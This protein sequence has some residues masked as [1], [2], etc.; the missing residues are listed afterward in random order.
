M[1][2]SLAPLIARLQTFSYISCHPHVNSMWLAPTDG[3]AEVYK[4]AEQYVKLAEVEREVTALLTEQQES[5]SLLIRG[6]REALA[7]IVA[8][9][10]EAEAE[11][12]RLTAQ[13]EQRNE[14]LKIMANGGPLS[15]QTTGPMRTYQYQAVA[16]AALVDQEPR[17]QL[18]EHKEP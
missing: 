2:K 4:D 15:G 8:H 11:V 17:P 3:I 18:Q 5:D 9:R 7:V 12:L 10:V 13:L 14:A 16:K 1:S 6:L